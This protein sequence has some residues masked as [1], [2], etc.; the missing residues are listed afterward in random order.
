MFFNLKNINN[1]NFQR[2]APMKQQQT[3]KNLC[4]KFVCNHR[5]VSYWE[6]VLRNKPQKKSEIFRKKLC[7]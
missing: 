3:M 6:K 4:W 1:N 5:S 7:R 2:P